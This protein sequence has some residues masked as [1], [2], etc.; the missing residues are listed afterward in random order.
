MPEII[1]ACDLHLGTLM[2]DVGKG[3]GVL[4]FANPA[5]IRFVDK[6]DPQQLCEC[7]QRADWYVT[8][9]AVQ[10]YRKYSSGTV[11]PVNPVGDPPE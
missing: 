6:T 10:F 4:W 3:R 8:V 11:V 9:G 7:G 1:A 2:R 5:S